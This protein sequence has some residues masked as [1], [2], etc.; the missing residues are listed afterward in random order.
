MQRDRK[1]HGF[2]IV[3]LVLCVVTWW[4]SPATGGE[5]KTS[6]PD[7]K[8]LIRVACGDYPPLKYRTTK[9]EYRGVIVEMVQ[10]ILEDQGYRVEF[11]TYPWNRL[12]E[13]TRRGD[14][15]MI[16]C[17]AP[18][19]APDLPRNNVVF[20]RVK[21]GIYVS[22]KNPW[23]YTGK[24]SLETA[25]TLG[26]QENYD[27]GDEFMALIKAHPGKFLVLAEE[28]T[29]VRFARMVEANRISGLIEDINVVKFE[30]AGTGLED[31][32]Q[33]AGVIEPAIDAYVGLSSKLPAATVT[34]LTTILDDGARRFYR[35]PRFVDILK[36]DGIYET[37]Y[38]LFEDLT[39]PGE[40][41]DS[42][43]PSK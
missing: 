43:R 38:P 35:S 15:D 22:K 33:L 23:K 6:D 8:P 36:R 11:Y 26:V 34:K 19:E 24:Q 3:S 9:G 17:D 1:L 16:L 25:G 13:L 7:G 32:L 29:I 41:R 37:Y 20:Q 5:G 28:N 31:K 39:K 2:M 27:Y 10:S 4:A 18:N 14:L 21:Y 12:Q 40:P 30:L 42:T